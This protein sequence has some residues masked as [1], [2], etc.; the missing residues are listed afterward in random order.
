MLFSEDMTNEDL[1][2]TLERRDGLTDR[3]RRAA[4]T[5]ARGRDPREVA[6]RLCRKAWNDVLAP[7]GLAITT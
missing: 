1:V 3:L 5:A 7:Y 4:I 6:R 2:T